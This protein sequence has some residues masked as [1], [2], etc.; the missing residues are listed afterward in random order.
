MAKGDALVGAS[1]P[2]GAWARNER[3]VA[4][5]GAANSQ[6]QLRASFLAV[7][8]ASKRVEQNPSKS[9]ALSRVMGVGAAVDSVNSAFAG[10]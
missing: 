1:Q 10:S 4:L 6:G 9:G 5:R 8:D 7:A 3:V 2:L